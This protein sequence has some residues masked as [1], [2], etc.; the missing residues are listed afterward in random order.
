M[1]EEVCF[2]HASVHDIS[3]V[4]LT[5]LNI[6]P[7]NIHVVLL[8]C[9]VYHKYLMNN[10][11]AEQSIQCSMH[12]FP[13]AQ[14]ETSCFTCRLQM[15]DILCTFSFVS[16][17]KFSWCNI[18]VVVLCVLAWMVVHVFMSL[19]LLYSSLLREEGGAL[20]II[21]LVT[22]FLFVDAAFSFVTHKQVC[23]VLW[24]CLL[25]NCKLT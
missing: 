17:Q 5:P 1:S 18:L 8:C 4:Q 24:T 3:A 25:C 16:I 22:T 10:E 7:K 2:W 12:R 6:R 20:N 21:L 9:H 14:P 13:N 23:H 19:S 15:L 11:N